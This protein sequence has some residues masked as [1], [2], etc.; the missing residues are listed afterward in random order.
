[1]WLLLYSLDNLVIVLYLYTLPFCPTLPTLTHADL[2]GSRFLVAQL[3]GRVTAL[4]NTSR[5]TLTLRTET[6]TGL[7]IN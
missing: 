2:S 6:N 5:V 1:L 4:V 3:R 7:H